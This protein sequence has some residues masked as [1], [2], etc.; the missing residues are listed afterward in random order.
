MSLQGKGVGLAQQKG[1]QKLF[2]L[3][4]KCILQRCSIW[5]QKAPQEGAKKHDVEIFLSG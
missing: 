4:S 3:L 5:V 2:F 1:M